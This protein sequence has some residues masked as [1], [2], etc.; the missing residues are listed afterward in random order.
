MQATGHAFRSAS[1]RRP[2]R[3]STGHRSVLRAVAAARAR[4]T[5]ACRFRTRSRNRVPSRRFDGYALHDA[6]EA[7]RQHA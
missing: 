6:E 7:A 3:L 4:T 1:L 5:P 2:D